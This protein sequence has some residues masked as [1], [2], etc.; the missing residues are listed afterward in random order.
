MFGFLAFFWNMSDGRAGL[1]Q[2][3]FFGSSLE[4]DR[5]GVVLAC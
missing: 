4:V 5:C 1:G 3:L 2:R